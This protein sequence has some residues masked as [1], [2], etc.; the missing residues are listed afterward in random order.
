MMIRTLFGWT[1]IYN[2]RSSFSYVKA[3]YESIVV[4]EKKDWNGAN[5]VWSQHVILSFDAFHGVQGPSFI[6]WTWKEEHGIVDMVLISAQFATIP[7][8]AAC[9]NFEHLPI[10]DGSKTA[11][12]IYSNEFKSSKHNCFFLVSNRSSK[13]D[14][15]INVPHPRVNMTGMSS[16]VIVCCLYLRLWLLLLVHSMTIVVQEFESNSLTSKWVLVRHL[17]RG[18]VGVYN[19]T[20][21][22]YVQKRDGIFHFLL[23]VA[24]DIKM[25]QFQ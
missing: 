13:F 21:F 20:S 4:L 14:S 2:S 18:S 16:F 9:F 24:S 1:I 19:I 8:I 7:T 5:C 23:A 3:K 22:V 11:I 12:A 15:P 10:V 25:M 6:Q 17:T